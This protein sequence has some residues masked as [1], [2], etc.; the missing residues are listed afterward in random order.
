MVMTSAV[1]QTNH[2]ETDI[3]SVRILY[4]SV[5]GLHYAVP[6]KKPFL[7]YLTAHQIPQIRN[8][9]KSGLFV[10]SI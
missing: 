8:C 5:I 10:S 9:L 7:L 1:A 3:R 2:L 6:L 4:P